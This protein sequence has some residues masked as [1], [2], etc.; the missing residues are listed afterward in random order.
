MDELLLNWSSEARDQKLPPLGP[1]L[2]S[3]VKNFARSWE[4]TT[5]R[6]VQTGWHASESLKEAYRRFHTVRHH[7]VALV[8]FYYT[9]IM[10]FE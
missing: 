5:F 7:F 6:V 9:V 10:Y 8:L 3:K 1:L 4:I 2:L